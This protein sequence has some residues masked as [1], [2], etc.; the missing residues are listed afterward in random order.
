MH[1]F[2]GKKGA[3]TGLDENRVGFIKEADKGTIFFD[4]IGELDLEIQTSLLRFI[5]EHKYRPLGDKNDAEADVR[6]ITATN[7][8][9]EAEV[10]KGKFREDL[11][12]RLNVVHI[13]MPS[14]YERKRD[15]PEIA[16]YLLATEMKKQAKKIKG[17]TDKALRLLVNY[18][19]PGNIRQ[20]RNVIERCVIFCKEN[21]GINED[22]IL[23]YGIPEYYKVQTGK[24]NIPFLIDQLKKTHDENKISEI[25][26]RIKEKIIASL[27]E[28]N[29]NK[30]QACDLCD[31]GS[32]RTFY[33]YLKEFGIE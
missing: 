28:T 17:I 24:Y 23:K 2:W 32:R 20:L 19:W 30:K 9:L 14:L 26:N 25:K 1:L 6:I 33:K 16:N 12:F 5:E 31:I 29:G 21:E 3:Y 8:E 15:I 4:E 22:L 18:E 11:F 10:E 13:T 7:K 27:E